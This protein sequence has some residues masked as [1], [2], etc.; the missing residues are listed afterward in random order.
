MRS[1]YHGYT[2]ARQ[3]VLEEED[4]AT[5]EIDLEAGDNGPF[6][7]VHED[8]RTSV[9]SKAQ[10]KRRVGWNPG[11]SEG[12]SLH[13]NIHKEDKIHD[14]A[15]SDDEVPQS[16]KVEAA[17]PHPALAPT[18]VESTKRQESARGHALYSTSARSVPRS[19]PATEKTA[20][21]ISAPPKP[22]DLNADEN[23][24]ISTPSQ[25]FNLPRP[26]SAM[27]GLDDYEKALWNWVNVYNLDAYLQEIYAYYEGKGIYS[28]VLYRGLNLL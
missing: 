10:G 24:R 21:P 8:L 27:R 26:R 3:S 12:T 15:D 5:E 20:S 9:S 13:P 28:I 14:Q 2:Q 1:A 19:K 17:A 22:S 16:F 6:R 18:F 4:E 25:D 23:Y 7:S 11:A